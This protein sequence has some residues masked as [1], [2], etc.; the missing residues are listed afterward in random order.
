MN[1]SFFM[2]GFEGFSNLLCNG[3]R[4]IDWYRPVSFDSLLERLARQQL[5]DE[6]LHALGMFKAMDRGDVRMIEC[7]EH[8]R[9]AL[10]TGEAFRI[11]R[12]CFR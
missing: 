6:I 9:F 7:P 8:F 2:R 12:K 3:Q 5:H 11:V 4:F 1:D 10:E